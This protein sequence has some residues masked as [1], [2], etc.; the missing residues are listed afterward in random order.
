MDKHTEKLIKENERIK[1]KI[2]LIMGAAPTILI[3]SS[4][5][6]TLG[7]MTSNRY[8]L[9]GSIVGAIAGIGTTI[10]NYNIY[11]Y[12]R[13]VSSPLGPDDGV[14]T[15]KSLKEQYEDADKEIEKLCKHI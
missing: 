9:V 7:A 3:T 15:I 4:G 8:L 2:D 5:L 13:V 10:H 12:D 6:L 14:W 1:K 11:N